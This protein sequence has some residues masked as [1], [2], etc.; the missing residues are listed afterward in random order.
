MTSAT[1]HYLALKQEQLQILHASKQQ[2][3]VLETQLSKHK[4]QVTNPNL[5]HC[6]RRSTS[7]P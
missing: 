6:Q 7:A 2:T 4:V 5:G 1:L 3:D